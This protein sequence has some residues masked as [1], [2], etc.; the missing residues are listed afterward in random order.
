[1]SKLFNLGHQ[2]LV[3]L[4]SGTGIRAG[5]WRPRPAAM[6]SA[7]GLVTL[8]ALLA[9]GTLPAQSAAP[10]GVSAKYLGAPSCASSS[11]HGG[12][13]EHQNQHLV[14]SLKDYHSQ[15]PV[16][17]LAT[18][19]SRQIADALHL[20]EPTTDAR[21]TTC[22]APLQAVPAA[23][24]GPGLNAAEG[25]TCESCHGPA[26]NWLRAHTRH[27]WSHAD[28]VFAGLRDL[29]NLYVRANTCVACHQTV[30]L[31]LL[32]AGHPELIFELDG[33]SVAEPRHW[34][35]ATHWNRAQT[36]YVGQAVALRELSWQLGREP[37]ADPHLTARWQAL[38]W[39]L[40]KLNGLDPALPGVGPLATDPNPDNFHAAQTAADTA[41]RTAAALNWPSTLAPAMLARLAGTAADFAPPAPGE[42]PARQAERLVLALDR[43]L[44]AQ[45]PPAPPAASNKLNDLFKA[46]QSVPDFEPAGF[47]A[48]LSQ[49]A[50]V[51]KP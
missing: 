47:A 45:S 1:M 9:P 18:A 34:Q 25:V 38:A 3:Q 37:Q 44:L 15:R 40:P 13:G 24:R 43:L 29:S 17:T 31:P 36:W 49:F 21:C 6:C 33:Q 16:A 51:V 2:A 14:W 32:Q 26:E 50:A 5:G 7:F 19:R 27:D 30:E 8:L 12:G 11:C 48:T 28:R 10:T 41:A 35:E 22:H 42:L 46:A 39:L 23:Q 20:S 4:S